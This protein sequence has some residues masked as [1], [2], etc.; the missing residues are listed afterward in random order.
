MENRKVE[1][2]S[3]DAPK[4]WDRENVSAILAFGYESDE[5]DEPFA[6]TKLEA[7]RDPQTGEEVVK[8]NGK[9][10]WWNRPVA[11]LAIPGS[12]R[13]KVLHAQLCRGVNQHNETYHF[14]SVD[15][16]KIPED[17]QDKLL[18]LIDFDKVSEFEAAQA[19]A[20]PI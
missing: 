19:G 12:Y 13:V 16:M 17:V 10:K 4:R 18:D 5:W 8:D 15:G 9:K 11:K 2:L 1:L 7:Q 14:V 3:L 6:L 20:A